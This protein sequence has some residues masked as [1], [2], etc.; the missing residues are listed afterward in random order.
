MFR[1]TV[2]E[3]VILDWLLHHCKQSIL[4]EIHTGSVMLRR[5]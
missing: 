3:D 4:L 2:L 1:D 5:D